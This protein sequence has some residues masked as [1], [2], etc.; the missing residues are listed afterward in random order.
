MTWTFRITLIFGWLS[1]MSLANAQQIETRFSLT[2]NTGVNSNTYLTPVL[3]EWDR[4]TTGAF[5]TLMPMA[6][7]Y[8]AGSGRN[9]QASAGGQLFDRTWGESPWLG[10]LVSTTFTQRL[11]QNW[12]LRLNGGLTHHQSDYSRSMQWANLKFNRLISSFTQASFQVG[13]SWRQYIVEEGESSSRYDTYGLELEHWFNFNWRLSGGFISSFDHITDPGRGF[14]AELTAGYQPSRDWN[15]NWRNSINQ[16]SEEFQPE[17]EGTAAETEQNGETY[18]IEDRIYRSTIDAR[19]TANR[20][21]TLTGRL[22]GLGWE[23]SID[24]RFITDFEVSAGVEVSIAPDFSGN[25]ELRDIEWKSTSSDEPSVVEV[26][27][28]GSGQLY[29]TGDFNDWDEPG[30]PLREVSRNRYQAEVDLSA[31][32]QE[33][34]I[35]VRKNDEEEW[36]DLPESVPTVTDSF[37]GRNGR[38]I[39]DFDN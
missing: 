24:D 27:Y 1:M 25:G 31:G 14:S 38:V 5:Y 39:V 2:G 3:S 34:R 21:V 9:L 20:Y 35:R 12:S 37:G 4:E 28:R 15:L 16:F 23:S 29:I 7:L 18:I 8:W 19:Y 32:S 30:I 10:G 26:R 33:Y 22:T 17:G 6:N 11:D 36:L 13:S